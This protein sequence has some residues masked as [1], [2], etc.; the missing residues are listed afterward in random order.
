MKLNTLYIA[1][2]LVIVGTGC[3]KDFLDVNTNPNALPTATPAFVL[4]NALN[5]SAINMLAPNETGMFWG[6]QWTQSNGYIISTTLFSYSF[7]NGDFNYWDNTYDNLYD[8]QYV[9]DNAASAN[10][11]YLKGPAKVMQA[12]AFQK[13]VDLYGNIPFSDALKGVKSLAPKFDDQQ[14]VYEG[15]IT[16]LDGAISDLKANAFASAY[17]SS[18]IIFKGSTTNWI[19]FANSLKLRILMRQAR[20]TGRDAYIT[21]EVN[22]IVAEGSGVLASGTDVGVNPGYT[23]SAGQINPFYDSYGYSETNARRANNNWPRGTEFFIN[24]LKSTGDTARLTRIFYA[25]GNENSASPGVSVKPEI[26]DNYVGVPFG[27]SAGFLP[28]VTSAPGPSVLV[29]GTYNKPYILMTAAEA[30]FN[31]AEAKQRYGSTVSLT[32]TAQSYYEAG[33]KESYRLLGAP[34]ADAT[35][36]LASGMQNVDFAASTN[37]LQAIG[38]QKWLCYANYNGLEAWSEYR[39]NNYPV[40]PQSKNYVGTERPLRLYYPGTEFGSNGANVTAQGTI[41][42]LATKIFWDID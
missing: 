30:Q 37:K 2:F 6:G 38:Y 1:A 27:S 12:L 19:K 10:Q 18:D 24:T 42:P 23:P 16:L 35:R 8:Y 20:V 13:L 26:A 29:R 5:Q 33:V 9:I 32:G 28:A 11:L 41:N 31:L 40:T 15:L 14:K 21:A 4:A 25:I 22:K 3:K 7:T 36:L 34:A 17:S 39:K